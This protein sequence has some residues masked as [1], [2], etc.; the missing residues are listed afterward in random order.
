MI[1]KDNDI[2]CISLEKSLSEEK[3]QPY[4]RFLDLYLR[5]LTH[6]GGTIRR[7]VDTTVSEED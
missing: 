5:A 3:S 6:T 1:D 7:R 4:E 2:C